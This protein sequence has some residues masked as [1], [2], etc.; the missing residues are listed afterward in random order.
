MMLLSIL[1]IYVYLTETQLFLL[2]FV[3]LPIIYSVQLVT[4]SALHVTHSGLPVTR[5]CT[6]CYI[7]NKVYKRIRRVTRMHAIGC[8]I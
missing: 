5:N 1:Y 3:A 8:I 6:T 2:S 4:H 7:Y